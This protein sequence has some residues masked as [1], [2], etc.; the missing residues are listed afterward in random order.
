MILDST[1]TA[2]Y[3]ED[4]EFNMIPLSFGSSA[5]QL[6]EAIAPNG[7]L[8]VMSFDVMCHDCSDDEV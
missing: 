4:G 8:A 2:F 5:D 1:E 7:V 6:I 3:G